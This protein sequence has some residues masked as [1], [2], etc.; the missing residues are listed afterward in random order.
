MPYRKEGSDALTQDISLETDHE[1]RDE[2]FNPCMISDKDCM[3]GRGTLASHSLSPSILS[4]CLQHSLLQLHEGFGGSARFG[5][6]RHA[7]RGKSIACLIVFSLLFR[8]P[9]GFSGNIVLPLKAFVL[10]IIFVSYL[11]LISLISL[12]TRNG[13]NCRYPP[14]TLVLRAG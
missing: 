5:S 2:K 12:K 4:L 9:R 11:S 6:T 14:L 7:L 13:E 10:L 8:Y 1:R 3:I